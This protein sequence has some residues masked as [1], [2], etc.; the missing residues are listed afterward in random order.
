[1]DNSAIIKE[2]KEALSQ[3]NCKLEV[4]DTGYF[5]NETLLI[6]KRVRT[7]IQTYNDPAVNDLKTL[8]L[9]KLEVVGG[10]W[11]EY[12]DQ[13]NHKFRKGGISFHLVADPAI[14]AIQTF[15]LQVP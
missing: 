3:L 12:Y 15:L 2:L 9:S 13:Y 7:L 11:D 14:D 10:R 5:A 4:Q 1:M 8:A 6:S